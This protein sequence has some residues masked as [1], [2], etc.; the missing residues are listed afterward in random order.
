MV[1]ISLRCRTAGHPLG[2]LA[3]VLP[4]QIRTFIGS[5]DVDLK[6]EFIYFF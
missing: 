5:G 6:Q 1:W 3:L 4:Q 2:M